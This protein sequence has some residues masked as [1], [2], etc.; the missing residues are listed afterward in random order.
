MVQSDYETFVVNE[1]RLWSFLS[2][3][4]IHDRLRENFPDLPDVTEK[5]VF[6]FVNRIRLTYNI[7][8]ETEKSCRP[9]EKQAETPYGK[10]VQ[11][12]LG[13]RWMPVEG[14]LSGKS[15]FL[16]DVPEPQPLQVSLFQ[17]DTVY[18]GLGRICARAC[19]QVL[20]RPKFRTF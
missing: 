12:D 16:Y 18:N 3:P 8:K 5:T 10:Y 4:Q 2:A 15:I 19:L 20:C 9:Y 17:Q 11:V 1:L 6:N 13:E 7:P 14:G